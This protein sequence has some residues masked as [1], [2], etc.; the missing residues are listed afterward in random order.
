[1]FFFI[2]EN[3]QKHRRILWIVVM[4]GILSYFGLQTSSPDNVAVVVTALIAPAMLT[5]TAWFA[6]TFG[7]IPAKLLSAAFSITFWMFVSFMASLT[8]MFVAVSFLSPIFI[9]PV[10]AIIYLGILISSIQYD[11]TDG[12]KVG[13]DDA[14]L[15]HS[16]A[17]LSYYKKQGINPE[18]K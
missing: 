15:K 9:L 5:G 6:I 4:V 1:V 18:E 7:G 10:L 14:I 17:A 12:L 8:T 11:T 3:I 2:E 16:R 13:L